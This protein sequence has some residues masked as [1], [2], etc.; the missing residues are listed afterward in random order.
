MRQTRYNSETHAIDSVWTPWSDTEFSI[1][2]EDQVVAE[3]RDLQ[4]N[5]IYEMRVVSVTE[6][7][8]YAPPSETLGIYTA[9][10]IDWTW[11]E[12]IVILCVLAFLGWLGWRFYVS[13]RA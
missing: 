3:V 10:P 9:M 8:R 5:T 2:E 6:D 13:R 12:R 4:P 1:S 7:G 11:F